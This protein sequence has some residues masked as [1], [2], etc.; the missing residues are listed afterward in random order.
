MQGITPVY[1]GN[2]CF[3][4]RWVGVGAGLSHCINQHG[5][6]GPLLPPAPSIPAAATLPKLRRCRQFDFVNTEKA[7]G[8]SAGDM[9]AVVGYAGGRVPSAAGKVCYYRGPAGSGA[10]AAA[11]AA[12][13]HGRAASLTVPVRRCL[14]Q[15]CCWCSLCCRPAGPVFLSPLWA[16]AAVYEELGHAEVV[17]VD[18]RG[19]MEAA[20]QQYAMFAQTYFKQARVG[21]EAGAPWVGAGKG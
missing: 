18:L 10:A 3:W 15:L 7:L 5:S 9:S 20:K 21:E 1:F 14:R 13:A 4:G 6:T 2:G 11:A 17:K 16:C 19:D 12:L 8:R